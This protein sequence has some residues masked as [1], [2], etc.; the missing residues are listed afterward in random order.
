MRRRAGIFLQA[1]GLTV[2]HPATGKEVSVRVEEMARFEKLRR[3]AFTLF[4][5]LLVGLTV[6]PVDRCGVGPRLDYYRRESSIV[7]TIKKY[8]FINRIAHR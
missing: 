4:S 3:R 1:V 8:T 2:T 6:Y 7:L 5:F